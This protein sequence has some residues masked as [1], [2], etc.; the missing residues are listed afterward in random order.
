MKELE[1]KNLQIKVAENQLLPVL[2]FM[3]NVGLNGLAGSAVPTTDFAA[4]EK[5]SPLEQLLVL[6]G[7]TPYTDVHEP[8]GREVEGEL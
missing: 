3:G 5:M 4:I 7:V 6:I 8:P 2:D 1:N